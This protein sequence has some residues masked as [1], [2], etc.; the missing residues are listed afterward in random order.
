MPLSRSR[1]AHRGTHVLGYEA[2]TM[3]PRCRFSER[4]GIVAVIRIDHHRG[5]L[6][7][8]REFTGRVG[9]FCRL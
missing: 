5:H 8:E 1:K 3:T 6:D 9:R 4:L 2:R 7:L